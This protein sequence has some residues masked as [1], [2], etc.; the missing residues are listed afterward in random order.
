MSRPV[1][2]LFF[3]FFDFDNLA[4][5]VMAAVGTNPMRQAHFSTV[6]TLNEVLRF[7]GVVCA[8][9]VAATLRMFSF[10]VGG[11]G[12]TPSYWD[13]PG[14]TYSHNNTCPGGQ[15]RVDYT[16]ERVGCQ[17]FDP[18]KSLFKAIIAPRYP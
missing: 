3:L 1:G 17:V 10:W 18:S 16:F 11:H 15:A 14:L 4:A 5:L 7:Q 8:T 2:Y 13:Q 6:A 12:L 9:A